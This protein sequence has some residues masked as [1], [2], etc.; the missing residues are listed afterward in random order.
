MPIMP[1]S[2]QIYAI[3]YLG[4]FKII[5]MFLQLLAWL[6]VVKYSMTRKRLATPT[7]SVCT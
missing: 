2:T 7:V 1:D 5:F 4:K 6:I 3:F